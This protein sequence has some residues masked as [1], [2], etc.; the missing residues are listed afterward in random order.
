MLTKIKIIACA[1]LAA[2]SLAA[3]GGPEMTPEEAAVRALDF[4]SIAQQTIRSVTNSENYPLVEDVSITLEENT[5]HITAAVSDL[6]KKSDALDCADTLV[7][8]LNL[9][10]SIADSTIKAASKDYYGGLYD[11]Y[12]LAIAIAPLSQVNNPANW[13][14]YDFVSSGM[15]TKQPIELKD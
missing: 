14:I 15:H 12:D 2:L 3:C 7:R 8:Q 4:E 9:Y 5:I 10:A 1:L 6:M 13:Y 11:V